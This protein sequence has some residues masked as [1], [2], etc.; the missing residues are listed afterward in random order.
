[1]KNTG[2][3]QLPDHPILIP[4][5]LPHPLYLTGATVCC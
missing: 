5:P 1:M 3:L 4:I 2:H